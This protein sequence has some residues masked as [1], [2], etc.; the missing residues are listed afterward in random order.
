MA[1]ARRHM[2]T[3]R[4]PIGRRVGMNVMVG[5][6]VL[7]DVRAVLCVRPNGSGPAEWSNWTYL[8]CI[9]G[10]IISWSRVRCR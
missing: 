9:G 6:G 7:S 1:K 10:M 2:Q 4:S 5:G 3:R 8:V